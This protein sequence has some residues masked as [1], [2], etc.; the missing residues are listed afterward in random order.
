MDYGTTLTI[1][2]VLE[3]KVDGLQFDP[4]RLRY[5]VQDKQPSRPHLVKR[6]APE[7]L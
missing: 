1:F 4:A 6:K 7:S 2:A 5:E 3:P